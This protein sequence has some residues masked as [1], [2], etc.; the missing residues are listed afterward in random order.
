VVNVEV[1]TPEDPAL[2]DGG[3]SDRAF[4]GSTGDRL[5]PQSVALNLIEKDY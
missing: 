3:D 1:T 5:L 2:T 4:W